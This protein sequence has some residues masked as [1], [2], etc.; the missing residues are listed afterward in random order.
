MEERKQ[1]GMKGR[2][3]G[4]REKGRTNEQTKDDE[5]KRVMVLT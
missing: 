2:G 5:G 3:K 4:V 1:G